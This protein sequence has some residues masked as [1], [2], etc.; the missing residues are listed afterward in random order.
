MH[1]HSIELLN[2]GRKQADHSN[3][4]LLAQ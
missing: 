3:I 4:G 1:R 2:N